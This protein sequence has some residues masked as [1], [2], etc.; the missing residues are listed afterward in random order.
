MSYR[1]GD[2][3]HGFRGPAPTERRALTQD[4]NSSEAKNTDDTTR[5]DAALMAVLGVGSL[6]L[7]A[8]R[9]GPAR[10]AR[11]ALCA[12]GPQAPT[13]WKFRPQ[14]SNLE[15]KPFRRERSQF[16]HSS[17]P[18]ALRGVA[19]DDDDSPMTIPRV[20]LVATGFLPSVCR[21]VLSS[22]LWLT[23]AVPRAE[24][25]AALAPGRLRGAARG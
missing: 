17:G 18:M 13:R 24:C 20:T 25:T 9:R 16:G 4:N 1:H 19:V 10:T 21:A 15:G 5:S 2:G 6:G 7:A 12:F 8:P 14:D 22:R 23:S 3:M 11:V